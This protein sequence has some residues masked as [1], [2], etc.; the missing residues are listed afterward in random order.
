MKLLDHKENSWY[1]FEEGKRFILH[2]ECSHSFVGY[3]FLM[4]LN[5]EE[6]SNYQKIGRSFLEQLANEIDFSCPIAKESTS[7]YK[8]R[9]LDE[10]Y[11]QK[12]VDAMP[13]A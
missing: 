2:V 5:D 1:F 4:F 8:G 10:S 13:D 6:I 9:N 3:D 12:A 11:I 7:K